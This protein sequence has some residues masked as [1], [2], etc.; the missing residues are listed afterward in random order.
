[1]SQPH[2]G[3][4]RAN[5]SRMRMIRATSTAELYCHASSGIHGC[6]GRRRNRPVTCARSD[7]VRGR[8]ITP[9]ARRYRTATGSSAARSVSVTGSVNTGA[10]GR[11]EAATVRTKARGGPSVAVSLSALDVDIAY[12]FVVL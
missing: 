7:H 8:P 11:W 4:T 12:L 2:I 1:M 10:D 5:I 9:I 6:P 3:R